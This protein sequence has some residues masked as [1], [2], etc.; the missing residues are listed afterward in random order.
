MVRVAITA[1][2]AQAQPLSSGHEGLSM[3]AHARHHAVDQERHAREIAGV[4]EEPQHEEQHRDL[5]DEDDDVADPC[6][7]AVLQQ[8]A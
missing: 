4:L 3:Q 1:G 8:V 7:D 6:D 5:R 2:T